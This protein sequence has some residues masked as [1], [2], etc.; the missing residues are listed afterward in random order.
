MLSKHRAASNLGKAKVSET[1]DC[2]CAEAEV[3]KSGEFTPFPAAAPRSA[4]GRNAYEVEAVVSTPC[5]EPSQFPL[6]ALLTDNFIA[7]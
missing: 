7:A 5:L 3:E 4:E 6:R 2:L 1:R